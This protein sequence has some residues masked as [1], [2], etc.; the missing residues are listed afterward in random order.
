MRILL[1]STARTFGKLK[2]FWAD[3]KY[4]KNDFVYL[5]P[6]YAPENAKSFVGY[7]ADGFKLE[8]HELLFKKCKELPCRFLLSNANVPLV[9]NAFENYE[10]IIINCKRSIN[11]KDPSAKT[12]EVLI[13]S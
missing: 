1:Q 8:D 3:K 6:P 11:S 4:L 7:T 10:T 9:T 13:K 12:N 5:D 2:K